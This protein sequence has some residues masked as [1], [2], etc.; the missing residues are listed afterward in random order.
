MAPHL[1]SQSCLLFVFLL[2]FLFF[3][4]KFSHILFYFFN[5]YYFFNLL[6]F[7]SH[8][9]LFSSVLPYSPLFCLYY[10]Q[11]RPFFLLHVVM[12]FY[13]FAINHFCPGIGVLSRP[14]IGLS[15][16]SYH[17]LPVPAMPHPIPRQK[18]FI[19]FSCSLWHSHSDRGGHYLL[20]SPMART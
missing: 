18:S 10:A 3:L 8:F 19:L 17:H 13:C 1:L 14:P 12:S 9:S 11:L 7:S 2:W 6:C 16:A 20:L 5:F 15:A 4:S